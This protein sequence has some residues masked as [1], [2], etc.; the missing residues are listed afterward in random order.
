MWF[1]TTTGLSTS[2]YAATMGTPCSDAPF[3]CRHSAFTSPTDTTCG[4]SSNSR[5]CASSLRIALRPGSKADSPKDVRVG[6]RHAVYHL[7]RSWPRHRRAGGTTSRSDPARTGDQATPGPRRPANARGCRLT[8]PVRLE[9]RG[10]HRK[11][12]TGTRSLSSNVRMPQPIRLKRRHLR[13]RRLNRR[14]TR[15]PPLRHR[16]KKP[17]GRW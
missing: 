16:R 4:K 1:P 2:G 10:S 8:H 12:L 6:P 7:S 3:Y 14:P 17:K 9:H 5:T 15:P 11:T 13:R